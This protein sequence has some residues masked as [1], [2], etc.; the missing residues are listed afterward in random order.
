M[1]IDALFDN[2]VKEPEYEEKMSE[3][4]EKY[5]MELRSFISSVENYFNEFIDVNFSKYKCIN[6]DESYYMLKGKQRLYF[7]RISISDRIEQETVENLEKY[8][9][10]IDTSFHEDEFDNLVVT[11]E[12][13]RSPIMEEVMLK[14]GAKDSYE[15]IKSIRMKLRHM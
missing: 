10:Y 5:I 1:N 4:N 12:K 3:L 7:K 8:F 2:Y 11:E 14:L 9:E 15:H 6:E 13:K